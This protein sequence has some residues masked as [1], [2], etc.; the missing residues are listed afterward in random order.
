M[1]MLRVLWNSFFI[2]AAC[3]FEKM[4]SM[5]FAYAISPALKRI[6]NEKV[7]FLF[8]LKRHMEFFNTHPYMAAPIIGAAIRLEEDIKNGKRTPEDVSLFKRNLMGPYGAIGDA[9]FWGSL[10]PMASVF[11]VALF[12]LSKNP[13][14]AAA[15]IAIYNIPH[16]WM[17]TAGLYAGYRMGEDAAFYIKSLDIPEWGR[18]I[19]Y[20]IICFLGA[21]IAVCWQGNKLLYGLGGIGGDAVS[22]V[23]IFAVIMF[24]SYLMRKGFSASML[25]YSIFVLCIVYNYMLPY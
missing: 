18:R 12:L 16:L 11:C 2:Q 3:S 7:E 15:F 1:T 14:A 4:Q 24:F 6:Y 22:A 20:V 17:R 23:G 19:R 25:V 21:A 10:K 5:G 9:F 13:L 8:A